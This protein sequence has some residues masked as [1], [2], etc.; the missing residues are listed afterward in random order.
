LYAATGQNDAAERSMTLAEKH[1]RRQLDKSPDDRRS[2]LFLATCVA[3][4]GRFEE[5]V[6]I[7]NEGRRVDPEGPYGPAIAS[8]YVSAYD[9]HA[10]QPQ[11]DYRAMI[12]ALKEALRFDAKSRDAA[13]RLATFGERGAGQFGTVA[14]SIDPVVEKSARDMLQGLLASGEQPPAVHMALGLKAWRANDLKQAQWH[15]ER[16]YELDPNLSGVAN[17]LA[18]V[19]SHQ[20]N[21]DL[22]RALEVIDPVISKFPQ[23]SHYRDTRGEIY[24]KME[25][26]DEALRDLEVALPDLKK[27]PRIHESLATVYDGLAQPDIAEKHRQ[28]A[29]KL[30]AAKPESAK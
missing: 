15:F 17:N 3:N 29:A 19:I 4:V 21:A 10:L 18:W 11:P 20:P 16:A 27:E 7:L 14:P 13:V 25:R 24:L 26:W 23:V 6:K 1:F 28:Q 2:R 5:A 30:K 22:N 9:R 12:T 8:I